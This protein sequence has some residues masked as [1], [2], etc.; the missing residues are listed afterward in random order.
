M[1]NAKRKER[2]KDRKIPHHPTPSGGG[3][4][5]AKTHLVLT[6]VVFVLAVEHRHFCLI[7][8]K[9]QQI[10]RRKKAYRRLFRAGAESM[11]QPPFKKRCKKRYF[12]WGGLTCHP[13]RSTAKG[14]MQLENGYSRG[15][16]SKFCEMKPREME[17]NRGAERRWDLVGSLNSFTHANV[18]FS[19]KGYW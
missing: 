1:V 8:G 12:G 2:N 14:S 4:S 9:K 3:E 16:Q 6:P 17:Q 18:T 5:N 15:A 7:R 10:P 19:I 13:E 11:T